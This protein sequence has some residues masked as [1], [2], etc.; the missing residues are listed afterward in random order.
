MMTVMQ[1]QEDRLR[2]RR[3]TDRIEPC[4]RKAADRVKQC[5]HRAADKVMSCGHKTAGGVRQHRRS[6]FADADRQEGGARI[7]TGQ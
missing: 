3:I 7:F 2:V 6:R 4:I 1:R 5:V